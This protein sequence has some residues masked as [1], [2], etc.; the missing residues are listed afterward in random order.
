MPNIFFQGERKYSQGLCHPGYRP[1]SQLCDVLTTHQSTLMVVQIAGQ[2]STPSL[3]IDGSTVHP[4][5]VKDGGTNHIGMKKAASIF[6][7]PRNFI[8]ALFDNK[9]VAAP[10]GTAE[11]HSAM[12]PIST[13][14][15]TE[16]Q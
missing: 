2:Q 16:K 13:Y 12:H 15:V 8:T 10:C 5:L 1:G 11:E 6:F 14:N 4:A 3:V 7:I 9:C